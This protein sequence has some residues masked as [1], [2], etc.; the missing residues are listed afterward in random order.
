MARKLLITYGGAGVWKRIAVP[1]ANG[2]TVGWWIVK[3]RY[4]ETLQRKMM[5]DRD[6]M[7]LIHQPVVRRKYFSSVYRATRKVKKCGS[8]W[9]T[10]RFYR[11]LRRRWL[12]Y[13]WILL[14]C[15]WQKFFC[16]VYFVCDAS[17]NYPL[18]TVIK[19]ILPATFEQ[20]K[21]E[22]TCKECLKFN[23][24]NCKSLIILIE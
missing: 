14:T 9:F 18:A 10:L 6:D 15:S 12:Y 5:N 23:R 17:E 22:V 20:L 4:L 19:E 8:D 3:K 21:W 16:S 7:R 24:I 1:K 11:T 2:R 13:S